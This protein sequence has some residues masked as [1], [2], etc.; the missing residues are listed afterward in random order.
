MRTQDIIARIESERVIAILRTSSAE[1]LR[2]LAGAVQAGGMRLVEFTLTSPR[3]LETL[4]EFSATASE[5][6]LLGAGT[7]LDPESC[8][9][10][11]LAGAR[12]IVTPTLNL[13]VVRLCRRYSV[14]VIPG[15]FTPT[16]ILTAWEAGADFVKVFPAGRLGP[17]YLK[18]LLGPLPQVRLV[19]TGGI[20]PDDAVEYLRAGASAV[21]VGGR[22]TSPGGEGEERFAAV[23][24]QARRLCAS[25][26]A[27]S[28]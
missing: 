6:L 14:P 23:T 1:D 7:V 16:E 17:G 27:L 24:E 11:I 21:G 3:A 4:A 25:V 22:L 10:A 2:P 12:F 26:A 19:P 13:E 5:D 15:A 28:R 8:R 9:G 20:G 18:D